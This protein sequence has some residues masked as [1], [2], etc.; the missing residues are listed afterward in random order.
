MT[1]AE[2]H[3]IL[4]DRTVTYPRI[5]VYVRTHKSDPNRVR[6]T[7]EGNLLNAPG[8]HST[9]IADMATIKILWNSVL[10]IQ[11][12]KFASIDIKDM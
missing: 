12:A 5:I 8:D 6:L 9:P 10:S 3:L 11:D 2:V 7:V 4:A 1:P